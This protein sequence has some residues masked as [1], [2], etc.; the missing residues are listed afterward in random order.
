MQIEGREAREYDPTTPRMARWDPRSCGNVGPYRSSLDGLTV[1]H[2]RWTP[3][4]DHRQHHPFKK[5]AL[6]NYFIRCFSTLARYLPERVLGQFGYVQYIIPPPPIFVTV[7]DVN[8]KYHI[9]VVIVG[10]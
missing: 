8:V 6:Y 2:V 7:E 10:Y 4:D 3:F 1:G 5:C 9:L